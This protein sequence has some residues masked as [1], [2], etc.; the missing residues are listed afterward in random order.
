MPLLD[1]LFRSPSID[2]LFT[3]AARLQGMLDFAAALARA[4]AACGIIPWTA[5]P[6]IAARCREE[7]FDFAALQRQAAHAGNLAIPMVQQLTALVA[8]EDRAS[9]GFVHWGA[10]SQD[11][12]DTGLVLQLRG[13]LVI[14]YRELRQLCSVLARLADE[15]RATLLPGRTWMQHAAP[16]AFG[17]KVAGW[18]DALHRHLARLEEVRERALVLQFGGAVGTL[19]ALGE[20]ASDVSDALA[21]ELSLALPEMPWHAHRD[22]FAEVA[23]MLGLLTGTLGKIARD[24]SLHAQTEIGELH[25]PSA[26]G[27]GASSAMPQKQNPVASAVALAAA[28][29]VP[30]LVS[31]MLAAMPQEDER[32]LGGWQAEWE[33]LPELVCLTGGALHHLLA[34]VSGLRVDAARMRENLELTRGLLYAEAAAIA[35]ASRLGKHEAHRVVEAACRQATDSRTHLREALLA[36]PELA[37]HFP[38]EEIFDWFDAR[39]FTAAGQALIDRVLAAESALPSKQKRDAS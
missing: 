5:A 31:T 10:T 39:K 34:A 38:R 15:H 17:V 8:A 1:T 3:D 22:R 35:A 26:P 9:A 11:A 19:S 2:A 36:S 13:A 4:E 14:L 33:V 24:I 27:R 18:L 6:S 21:K 23:T 20:K 32:G 29:R 28:A 30:A 7:L 25:E 12:M 16:L 37:Q